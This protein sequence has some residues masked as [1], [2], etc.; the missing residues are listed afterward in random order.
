MHGPLN[1]KFAQ[2]G[3]G[4]QFFNLILCFP[5]VLLSYF[6]NGFEMVPAAL[7]ITGI[8]F[9]LHASCVVFLL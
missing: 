3:S 9:F 1:V 7:I 5:V 6:L 4:R 8:I 2:C